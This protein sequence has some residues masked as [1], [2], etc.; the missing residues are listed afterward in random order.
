M[1]KLESAFTKTLFKSLDTFCYPS[2]NLGRT[3]GGKD[4]NLVKDLSYDAEP[5]CT[6][7]MYSYPI[8]SG[9]YPVVF[10]IHGGGFVAGDKKYRKALSIWFAK[11]GLYVVCINYGIAPEYKYPSGLIHI[12]KA[13]NWTMKNAE[14]YNLDT[15]KIIL[16]GD[17]A[18][19]YY[20]AQLLC[21]INNPELQDVY[22]IK[23]EGK[24]CSVIYN[25]GLYDIG[26]VLSG[27][28][29]L[30]MGEKLCKEFLG[31]EVKNLQN[32]EYYKYFSPINWVNDKM[33][34]TFVIHAKQ[35]FFC[36]GHGDVMLKKL[37]E[38]KIYNESYQ[39]SKFLDNHCF[40]LF[41]NKKEAKK[42]NEQV[43]LFIEKSLKNNF[44]VA[45]AQS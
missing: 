40:S 22:K 36:G 10:Y 1:S 15:D 19:A 16:S 29:L 20:A 9:K 8:K 39:S 30:N 14:K 35:D 6:L 28:V 25:C 37:N 17:S 4:L 18:G 34:P 2:C 33:P 38:L 7:D 11:Q 32:Y 31:C 41:W 24:F 21:T 23:P 3:N 12:I 13:L 26:T 45:S 43:R 27:K 44:T 5:C 42:C